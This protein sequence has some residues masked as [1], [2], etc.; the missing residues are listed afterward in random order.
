VAARTLTPIFLVKWKE[1]ELITCYI[2][3]P[4]FLV[5]IDLLLVDKNIL[6]NEVSLML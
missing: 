3:P 6:F 5:T 1:K 2:E 4:M